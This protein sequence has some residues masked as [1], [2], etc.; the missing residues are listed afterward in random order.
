MKARISDEPKVSVVLP[1]YNRADVLSRAIKSV[2]NQTLS[3]I[4]LIIVDDASDDHTYDVVQSFD[5]ERIMYEKHAQNKGGGAARNTGISASRGKYIAFLDDDDVWYQE[6]LRIQL[7]S[8]ENKPDG[9]IVNYCEADIVSEGLTGFI[10]SYIGSKLSTRNVKKE[11][12]EELIDDI[13][14]RKWFGPSGSST[15]LM[16][17]ETL[18]QI[19]G[20]D[21][22]FD[23]HQD[24]ELLIRL[25]NNGKLA[26]LNEVLV[27]KHAS[28]SPSPEIMIDSKEKLLDKFADRVAALEEDGYDVRS[29]HSVDIAIAA[30]RDGQ[31]KS[32]IYYM[33]QAR[34]TSRYRYIETIWSFLVGLKTVIYRIVK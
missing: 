26:H 11:G 5:D 22:S 16:K 3:D 18:E 10:R 2:L 12:G 7:D 6:K 17:R 30:L 21:E 24:V 34:F 28:G 13:L 27:T 1:T 23:R 9:Y 8:L 33:R 14:L 32:G 4:E 31:I 20:F 15:L 25:L 19:S 29:R